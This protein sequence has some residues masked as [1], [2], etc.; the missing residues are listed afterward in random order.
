[1]SAYGEGWRQADVPCKEARLPS[2]ETE[3][4]KWYRGR[5]DAQKAAQQ[6]LASVQPLA[7]KT[8]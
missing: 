5:R 3:R 2:N 4:L 7:T 8:R 6:N 1:M